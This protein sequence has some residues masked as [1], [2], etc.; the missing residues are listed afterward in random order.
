MSETQPQPHNRNC[1]AWLEDLHIEYHGCDPSICV[2][3]A[4]PYPVVSDP[5][6][7]QSI[8]GTLED[9][10]TINRIFGPEWRF[11][12]SQ[13]WI[14]LISELPQSRP[15]PQKARRSFHLRAMAGNAREPSRSPQKRHRQTSS[16]VSGSP[17]KRLAVRHSAPKAHEKT[18]ATQTSP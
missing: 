1:C 10:E 17:P 4:A 11:F 14:S 5:P 8:D 15:K 13:H 16:T 12:S 6:E 3:H 9:Q 7:I 18:I 2:L